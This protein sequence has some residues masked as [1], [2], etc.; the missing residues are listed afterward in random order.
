[1]PLPVMTNAANL[2]SKYVGLSAMRNSLMRC[3][4]REGVPT[5][6]VMKP[7]VLAA[8]SALARDQ[9]KAMP[10]APV[11]TLPCGMDVNRV[12]SAG[13]SAPSKPAL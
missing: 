6:A 4:S 12:A 9:G 11:D 13:S 3:Q 10:L 8:S 7:L 2:L 5:G 1:M